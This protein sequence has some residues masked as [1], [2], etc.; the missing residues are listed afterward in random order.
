MPRTATHRALPWIMGLAL[1]LT[2]AGP[3]CAQGKTDVVT[4]ANGDRIT[5]EVKKLERGR[6]EFSTDDA[7]TLYFEWD[8]LLSVVA[9]RLVEVVTGS[10]DR[11]LGSLGPAQPRMIS[12]STSLADVPL[13]MSDVTSILPIG[14]SFWSKLDGSIDAGFTYTQSSGIAQLTFNSQTIFRKPASSIRLT[15]SA[16]QTRQQS[17]EADDRAS[18]EV[19][20]LRFPWQRWF[21]LVGG[22]FE[23]NES[24]GLVLRSQ[25]A[26]AAGPRLVNSNRAQMAAG[27]GVVVNNEQGVD[28][29]SSQNVEALLMWQTS[30]FT[31]DSPKTNFDVALQYYPSLSD[32]GRQRL[33]LD[34][35]VKREFWKDFFV[36][37]S[38][39]NTYDSRPPNPEAEKNDV[40]VV[41]SFGWSY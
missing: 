8:K 28:V 34:T 22:R 31:Y 5:G 4:L 18:L 11:F 14:R 33:Q 16:T 41:V 3:L 21:V 6:L 15:A 13:H 39:Y 40:G 7:G 17:G 26:A 20:H 36:S 29:G 23:N 12:V 38:L 32:P 30:Y 35:A 10:G 1:A 9:N 37:L 19:S 24:L 27:A 25:A 2:S